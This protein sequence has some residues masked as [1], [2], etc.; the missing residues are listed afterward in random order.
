MAGILWGY[1]SL[2]FH[3]HCDV[4]RHRSY[5]LSPLLVEVRFV[6]IIYFVG[7]DGMQ[8][9][10]LSEFKPKR[11]IDN[12]AEEKLMEWAIEQGGVV[13]E[14]GNLAVQTKV[15]NRIAKFTEVVMGK[16]DE[17]DARLVSEVMRYLQDKEMIMLD[18]IMCQAE[19]YKRNCRLYVTAEY[20]RIPLMWGNF[21]SA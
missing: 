12:L 2:S 11:I 5:K 19:G 6:F 7:S 21:I 15:R 17:E 8:D 9:I 1:G 3:A 20:A 18:R 10:Y 4:V 13:T 14:F 16:I